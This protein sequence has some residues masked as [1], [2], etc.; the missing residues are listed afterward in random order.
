MMYCS[1]KFGSFHVLN[2]YLS[3]VSLLKQGTMLIPLVINPLWGPI[4]VPTSLV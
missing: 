3:L 4:H 2:H 1:P